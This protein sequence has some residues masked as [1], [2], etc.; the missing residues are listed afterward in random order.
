MKLQKYRQIHKRFKDMINLNL[1]SVVN[2]SVKPDNYL[3][4]VDKFQANKD[5][6]V[7]KVNFRSGRKKYGNTCLLLQMGK[8]Y[9]I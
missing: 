4:T 2:N 1:K 7:K 6:N 3:K 8:T 9:S 5:L